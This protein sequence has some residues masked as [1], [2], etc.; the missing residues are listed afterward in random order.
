MNVSFYPIK[1]YNLSIQKCTSGEFPLWLSGLQAQLVS[2][3]TQVPS[4]ASLSG[5]R[6]RRCLEMQGR[7]QVWL[8]SRVAVA[9]V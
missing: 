4:L 8:G 1:D 5:L 3:R 7:L 6:I 9:V 2:M